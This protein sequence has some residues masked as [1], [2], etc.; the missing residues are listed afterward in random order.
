MR[1]VLFL[2]SLPSGLAAISSSSAL[3][4]RSKRRSSGMLRTAVMAAESVSVRRSGMPPRCRPARRSVCKP[5]HISNVLTMAKMP[6]GSKRT[7]AFVVEYSPS[8]S[9][10]SVRVY[11]GSGKQ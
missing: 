8:C 2:S 9:P 7:S 11:D 4:L 6:S 5:R 1:L 10:S 3:L